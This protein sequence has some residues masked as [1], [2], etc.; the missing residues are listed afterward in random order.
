MDFGAETLRAFEKAP[1][2]GGTVISS[3]EEK[4]VNLLKLLSKELSFRKKEFSDAG[5]D[6]DTYRNRTGKILPH[7]IVLLNNI[8]V[9]REQFE[10]YAGILQSLTSDGVKYGIYF[11][12]TASS[13][14]SVRFTITQNFKTQLVMQMNDPSDYAVIIGTTNGLRPMSCA[15][16]GLVKIGEVY[17]FQ[18]ARC[19]REEDDLEYIRNFCMSLSEQMVYRAKPIPVL[20]KEVTAEYMS[21]FHYDLSG[22]PIGVGKKELTLS[23]LNL[24]N[25][26]IYPVVSQDSESCRPFAEELV[27]VISALPV[28][29]QY[30]NRE[31]EP[32]EQ[33][34]EC[35]DEMVKRNNDYVDSGRKIETMDKYEQRVVILYEIKEILDRLSDDGKDKFHTMLEHGRSLF[36][37]HFVMIDSLNELKEYSY[38]NWYKKN[39]N[40]KDGIWLG[41][42]VTDQ[43]FLSIGKTKSE[44]YEE[45]GAL[46][47]YKFDKGKLTLVKLLSSETEEE[48]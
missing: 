30:W 10:D 18:T 3:D 12:A 35:F 2:C 39:F 16:R 46:Y 8:G 9:F 20:P 29:L 28:R 1:H 26:L 11:V 6:F 27:R 38:Q 42:G 5:G 15:G 40:S 13:T 31:S 32:E 47:G 17:E 22:V 36:G 25:V 4:L 19:V 23:T 45:I 7:I 48:Y 24:A 37:I 33:V 44:Y 41:D 14:T 21:R 43:Y 34:V